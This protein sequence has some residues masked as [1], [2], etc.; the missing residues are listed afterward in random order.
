LQGA[1]TVPAAAI[2]QGPKGAYVYLV[3]PANKAVVQPVTVITTE[4]DTAVVQ[5]GLKP[6]QLVVTDGQMALSPGALVSYGAQP[7]HGKP[8]A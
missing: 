1:V 2:N 4:G 8:G 3:G 5:D 7:A 6:G